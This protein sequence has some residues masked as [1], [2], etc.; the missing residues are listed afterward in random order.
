LEIFG[1]NLPLGNHL[2]H[3]ST[4]FDGRGK[5]SQSKKISPRIGTQHGVQTGKKFDKKGKINL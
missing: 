1:Q 3:G 4:P 2:V 5:K